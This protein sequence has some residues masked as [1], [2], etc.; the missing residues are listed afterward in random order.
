MRFA[1]CVLKC[2][3]FAANT[4]HFATHP[5]YLAAN[6]IP[7]PMSLDYG[8]LLH[9]CDDPVCPDPVWKL[10]RL[11][12]ASWQATRTHGL[13]LI[14]RQ[15]NGTRFVPSRCFA[16]CDYVDGRK[17]LKRQHGPGQGRHRKHIIFRA[18]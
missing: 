18:D 5:R 14:R 4:I 17:D 11:R 1:V 12:R 15:R 16:R 6:T 2:A 9:F 7:F 3:H 13:F 8:Q 10:S